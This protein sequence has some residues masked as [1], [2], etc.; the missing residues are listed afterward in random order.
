MA[1]GDDPQR[2]ISLFYSYS[3]DDEGLLKLLKQ[4]LAALRRAGLIAEW[5][6]RDINAGDEWAKEI[7]R[8][9]S[10]ADI[11]LLLV[12]PSFIASEYC[13]SVEVAKA[14]ERNDRGEATVVPVILRPCRWGIT[15]FAKLQAVPKDAVA[16]TAWSDIDAAF[17]DVAAKV[18]AVALRTRDKRKP[19]G[20][21][22]GTHWP[23]P[24]WP[25]PA[26]G[27][28]PGGA[29]IV[30]VGVDPRTLPDLAVFRDVDAP[31]CPEM[32]VIPKGSFLMGSPESDPD[33]GA[34]EKPQ[35]LVTFGYRF[36]VGQ[37]PVTFDEY[38]QFCG[39]S[40]RPFPSDHG[41][42]RRKRPAINVSWIDANAYCKW[43]AF[44]SGKEYRL[45][46]ESEW[47][48]ACRAST[49]TKYACGD[50]IT[51]DH[52][53]FGQH[54]GMTTEVCLYPPNTWGLYDMHGNVKE[55]VEDV[56]HDTYE[57]APADGSASTGGQKKS[58]TFR[59]VRGGSWNDFAEDLWSAHS[60]CYA[61]TSRTDFKGFRVARTLF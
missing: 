41:W 7:D 55:W 49:K 25:P 14:L 22:G 58:S 42:G 23:P 10:S 45:L 12:S 56:W 2:P 46:S 32:V 13:W 16:A 36:A 30:H 20:P 53:N 15:P 39:A 60:S 1:E 52:A 38:D 29:G 31:W 4:H 21:G 59:I 40:G 27:V 61:P 43:L 54:V 5:Y 34:S 11:I 9:L 35:H 50:I 37:H 18:E 48:Y 33:A 17:D 24:A 44:E 26:E 47:E 28:K 51:E 57:G 6:D 8:N 3:H 19:P